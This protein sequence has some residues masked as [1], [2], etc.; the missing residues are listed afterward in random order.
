[1][2]SGVDKYGLYTSTEFDIQTGTVSFKSTDIKVKI[3]DVFTE[4]IAAFKLEGNSYIDES[5]LVKVK[6]QIDKN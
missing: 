1:L 2:R 6:A 5:Y 3:N 4:G